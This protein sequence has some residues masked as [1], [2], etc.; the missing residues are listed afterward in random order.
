MLTK[1]TLITE[2]KLETREI[3]GS[4]VIEGYFAVFGG[5]YDMGGG[6]KERIGNTAFHLDR[7][8][9][10]RALINHDTTLVMGRTIPKTLELAVD[11]RGL[12]GR[13][14]VNPEDPNAMAAHARVKRGDVTQCSM[15]FNILSR[16]FEYL[17]DGTTMIT[18][19][20]IELW[21][22]SI[23]TFPAYSET[24]ITARSKDRDAVLDMMAARAAEEAA[25]WREV[26]H[27]K[28]K[29]EKDA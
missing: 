13:I 9:D 15:G 16:S 7:D 29:G 14:Y 23:C 24:E 2:G 18:L 17:D 22:V 26:M 11:A 6:L 4:P 10:V 3:D 28:L 25:E 5:I 1:R 19:D 8:R 20:D 21:E 27:S 12:W